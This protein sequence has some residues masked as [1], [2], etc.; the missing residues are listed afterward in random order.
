MTDNTTHNDRFSRQLPIIGAAG[1]QRLQQ[2]RVLCIGAGGLGCPA[3]LY[4][5]AAGVGTIGIVD[6][7]RVELSNLQRQILYH[8][9]DIGKF[10]AEVARERCLQQNST[11]H[12]ISYPHHLTATNAASLIGDYDIILDATDNYEARYVINHYCRKL[13]KPLISASVLQHDAQIGIFNYDAGA[14]Y[15]CLYPQAPTTLP[16]CA[17]AGVIGVVP[18]IAGTL[19]ASEAIKLITAQGTALTSKLLTIN[20]ATLSFKTFIIP[21]NPNCKQQCEHA[22]P[23]TLPTINHIQPH[24]LTQLLHHPNLQ[25]IDVRELDERAEYHIGGTHIPL[26]T[27]TEQLTTLDPQR[28]TVVYCRSGRRS[29]QGCKLLLEHGFTD[30]HNLEGGLLNFSSQP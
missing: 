18:G 14:C 27:L 22:N 10:K 1:Q 5:N 23:A 28:L 9:T 11:T 24:E 8:E 6:G 21:R 15:Q 3:L 13:N 19:Q 12:I 16:N 29:T 17:T 2:A 7:D 20:L 26:A 4:L 25:L 30:V